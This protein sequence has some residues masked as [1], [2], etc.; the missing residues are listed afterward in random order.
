MTPSKSNSTAFIIFCRKVRV[1]FKD[2]C[3]GDKKYINIVLFKALMAEK[4]KDTPLFELTLRKYEKPSVMSKRELVKKIC[5]SLGLLQPGDSRDVIIDVLHVILTNQ[6]LDSKEVENKVI[7]L[8][9]E[10]NLPL[11]GIASS[12]IRRQLKRLK[13][14]FLIENAEG[15][16]RKFENAKLGEVFEERIEKFLLPSIVNRVKEYLAEVDKP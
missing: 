3:A 9:Q 12:N 2:C 10:Q 7:E 14:L 15:K 16:Y 8:R 5:L 1:L 11:Q 6:G 13:D 4:S